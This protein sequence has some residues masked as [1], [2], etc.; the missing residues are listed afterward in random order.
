MEEQQNNNE[1]REQIVEETMGVPEEQQDTQTEES[2]T[3][4]SSA[5]NPEGEKEKKKKG[6]SAKRETRTVGE[7]YEW[8]EEQ[9]LLEPLQPSFGVAEFDALR[10]EL[11]DEAE[12]YDVTFDD[13]LQLPANVMNQRE[14]EKVRQVAAKYA[15]LRENARVALGNLIASAQVNAK[16]RE[17]KALKKKLAAERK[18]RREAK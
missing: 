16:Q 14:V 17:A 4:T 1:M 15:E 12:S 18:S 11:L 3:A 5:T 2:A 9:Q 8:T 10:K 6:G 13:V 7:F